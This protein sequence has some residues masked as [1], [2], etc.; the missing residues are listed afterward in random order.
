MTDKVCPVIKTCQALYRGGFIATQENNKCNCATVDAIEYVFDEAPVSIGMRAF[1]TT[2]NGIN[3]QIQGAHDSISDDEDDADILNTFRAG[4]VLHDLEVRE[5]IK[6]LIKT[7]SADIP[8]RQDIIN[9]YGIGLSLQDKERALV[10][11]IKELSPK[12]LGIDQKNR[13][14]NRNK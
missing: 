2:R 10:N 4:Q 3:Q 13:E 14:M 11:R 5:S 1:E 9:R 6:Q 12:Y 7:G 8:S